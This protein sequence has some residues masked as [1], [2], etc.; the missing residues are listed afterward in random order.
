VRAVGD[1]R[2]LGV[3]LDPDFFNFNLFKNNISKILFADLTLLA[4]SARVARQDNVVA[5]H[6]SAWQRDGAAP[7]RLTRQEVL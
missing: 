4:A 7:C 1:Q 5:P 2:I 6:A 3:D